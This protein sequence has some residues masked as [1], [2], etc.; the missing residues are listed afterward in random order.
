MVTVVKFGTFW[1]VICR[2][3]A[4]QEGP[5]YDWKEAEKLRARHACAPEVSL[6]HLTELSPSPVHSR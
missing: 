5:V 6:H 3:C 4:W 2:S 1:K